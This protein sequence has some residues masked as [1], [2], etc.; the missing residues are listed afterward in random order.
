MSKEGLADR[1]TMA[2]GY[3]RTEACVH[4]WVCVLYRFWVPMAV[5]RYGLKAVKTFTL[6]V[7]GMQAAEIMIM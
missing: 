6:A 7:C 1:Y 5:E 3:K 2:K 4:A